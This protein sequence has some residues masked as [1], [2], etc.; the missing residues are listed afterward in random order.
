MSE[1]EHDDKQHTFI[2]VCH[3]LSYTLLSLIM[4]QHFSWFIIAIVIASR[5]KS[6]NADRTITYIPNTLCQCSLTVHSITLGN[7]SHMLTDLPILHSKNI[8]NITRLV[9]RDALIK[10]PS[11]LCQY[12]NMQILDLSGSTLN[13]SSV[14]FSCLKYLIHVNLSRT[15]LTN[16][17]KFESNSS[18]H[19]QILDL[20]NNQIKSVNAMYFQSMKN[21][22]SVFLQNNPIR[23]IEHI[24]ELFYLPHLTSI[25]LISS[26]Q[27]VTIEPSLTMDQWSIVA[28]Q[29]NRSRKSFTLRTQNMPFQSLISTLELDSILA[30]DI[31]KII[32]EALLNSTFPTPLHTHSCQCNDLRIYQRLFSTVDSAM[33]YNSALFQSTTCLMPDRITHGRLFDRRTYIDLHCSFLQKKTFFSFV[34]HS[35]SAVSSKAHVSCFPLVFLVGFNMFRR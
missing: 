2:R 31:M 29:W 35:S 5:C 34:P 27:T 4:S 30:S 11:K 18:E 10:W 3:R 9:A 13:S 14:E 32:F 21:L 6:T 16:V 19:L 7:C 25:H 1:H 23:L 26:N 12:I 8:V 33:K 24:Q 22:I 15:Q 20:S 28:H 17:P